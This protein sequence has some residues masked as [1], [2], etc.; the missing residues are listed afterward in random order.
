MDILFLVDRLENLIAS[1]SRLP[2]VNQIVVK[3]TE[4]L[5]IVDQMR[6]VIPDELKQA[7]RL[8]QEKERL[9]SQA[10]TE[11]T[12]ILTRARQEADRALGREEMV[13]RAHDQAQDIL[14][15]A[16]TETEQMKNEADLYVAETLRALRDHLL[17]IESNVSHSILSIEK[18][19]ESLEAPLE[20]EE[21][22]LHGRK[23]EQ[24]IIESYATGESAEQDSG[25]GSGF[26][27]TI[28]RSSLA[29]DTHGY[30]EEA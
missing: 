18:G 4:I 2:L 16:H 17:S 7:R 3:E 19:I 14:R 9:I 27:R 8:L 20:E 15:Q 26:S 13:L 11:A 23:N 5:T 1:S 6:T 24:G 10:Q 22:D 21:D 30:A 12:N 28:R 29:A 25:S